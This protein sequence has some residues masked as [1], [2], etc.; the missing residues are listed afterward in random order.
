MKPRSYSP[1]ARRITCDDDRRSLRPPSCC[2]VDVMNGGLG[3]DL[4]GLSSTERI[5]NL[6]SARPS[7]SAVVLDSSR[8][9]TPDATTPVQLTSLPSWTRVPSTATGAAVKG[10]AV[11]DSN[12]MSQ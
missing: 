3:D 12:S 10:G 11:A 9:T 7:A 5:V 6:A 8:A 2:N 4:Y 1:C